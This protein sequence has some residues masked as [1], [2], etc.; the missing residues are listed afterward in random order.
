M[1]R[2]ISKKSS[3]LIAAFFLTLSFA[4]GCADGDMAEV[5]IHLNTEGRTSAIRPSAIDRIISFITMSSRLEAQTAQESVDVINISIT[6]PDMDPVS[7]TGIS[8]DTT[9]VTLYVPAGNSRKITVVAFED[10]GQGFFIRRYGGVETVNLISGETRNVAIDMGQLPN[11][12]DYLSAYTAQQ[13]IE[14]TWSYSIEPVGLKGFVVYK[15]EAASSGYS[16]FIEGKKEDFQVLSQ[17]THIDVNGLNGSSPG[18]PT[19]YKVSATNQ[20]GEGEMSFSTYA[21]C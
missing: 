10:S 6:G 9:T 4:V 13:G 19:Y 20:Y 17:Y 14:L 1:I 15:S 3:L 16:I 5:T 2:R 11:P 18:G 21:F 12:P 7:S 8:P